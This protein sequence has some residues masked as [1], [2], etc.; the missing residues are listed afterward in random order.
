MKFLRDQFSIIIFLLLFAGYQTANHIGEN[1]GAYTQNDE[2]EP[3][4]EDYRLPK[5]II[6]THY[7]IMLS[8]KLEQSNFSGIVHIKAYVAKPTDRI[9]LHWGKI[10][11][12]KATVTSDAQQLIIKDYAYNN[13]TEKYAIILEKVLNV[14]TNVTISINYNGTL[15]DDMIGFYKSSYVD[16]NGKIR[17]LLSTQFQTT[18]AR[19]AFPCFDEPSFKASFIVRLFRSAEYAS[20]SNMP[21]NKTVKSNDMYWDEF[22]QS[23]PMS[24]YLVAFIISDFHSIKVENFRVWA[25]PNAIDQTRYALDIGTQGLKH[26]SKRFNQNYQIPKMDMVAVPDFSA[27]A[28]ENWGLI[29]YRESRLLYAEGL[30]S[31]V[32]KQSIASVIVHE[33]THMW[34]GNMITPE[35]WS[36]LWLSEAFARYFQYFGTA[37]IETTWNMEEQFVVEQHQTAYAADGVETSEPMTRDVSNASQ[38]SR[39]GDTITYNKG[40]SIVRMMNLIFGSEVFDAGLQNYLNNTVERVA[41]PENLWIELQSEINRNGQ[42][43]GASVKDI[44]T[45]WTEQAGFPVLSVSIKNNLA[46]LK[47][48]RFLLRNLKSTPTKLTWWIPLTWTTKA[49]PDFDRLNVQHWMSKELDTIDLGK[50]SGWVIFNIQ[51]SGFYRVNYDNASWYRIF[52]TLNSDNYKDVHVLNRAA[53]VDDLLNLARAGLLSYETTLDGLLY[54]MRE[55]NYLPFK[56]LFSGLTYLDQRLSGNDE[57]YKEF[58]KFVLILIDNI[59]QKIGYTDNSRDDRLTVLLRNELNKW[60]CN[61]GHDDCVKIFTNIFQQ[62]RQHNVTIAPNQHPVAYCMGVKHGTKEDWE[63]LW[64]EY[65]NSN[66]ATQQI[67]ILQALGCTEDAALLEKYLLYALKSFEVSRIRMQDNSAVFSA[68]SG[69]GITGAKFVLDFVANHLAEMV[70]FYNGTGS[71]SSILSS[72]SQRFSTQTLMDKFEKLIDKHKVEFASALVSLRNSLEIGKY[73]LNWSTKY[74]KQII[75]WIIKFNEKHGNNNSIKENDTSEYRLPE[76]ITPKSYSIR[77]ATNVSELDN[78]TFTGMVKINAVVATT[79]KSITLHSANLVNNN[80]S[81]L[82]GNTKIPISKIDI[83]ETYD[84]LIIELN[85]ELQPNQNLTI[86]I[87]FTGYLNEEMRGFYRSS[88]IDS[89]GQTRWLATTHMEPVGAR[90]MFPCFDEPAMKAKFTM[91]AVLP[92]NY[93]AISNMPI[94]TQEDDNER[95][96]IVFQETPTMS[97]YL[98]VLVVSDFIRVNEDTYSVW[99]RKNA[100]ND[101][102]YALSVMK[103]LVN[104]YEKTL[105]IPYQLP[106][107]DMV[108]LPDFVSGAM[109]NWGL[110]TYKERNVLYDSALSTTAS[111]QSIINV[112]SHEITHQWFGN[113]VSPRWWKYLWLN[114]GFARYFQYFGTDSIEQDW[115]L[116]AQFVVEQLHS[117]LE[118][119]SAASTH[120]MTHDVYSPTEIRGIFDSISYAKAASVIRMMKKVYGSDVFY[121]ALQNYLKKRQYD[122]A[123]PTDLFDAFKEQ[124]SNEQLRNS[125]HEIM[126][127]WTVQPGYPVVNVAIRGNSLELSQKRFL[128][129]SQDR[130]T[131]IWHI[132]ITWTNLNNPNFENIT[133]N[134]W[135]NK[136]RSTV[137]LPSDHLYLINLQQSGFYRVNY[138]TQ[139]W[140]RIIAFLKS[141]RYELIHEINRAALIDDLLNLG[142]AGQVDYS[143]VLSA[144]QYLKNETNYIPWRAFFNGLTYLQKQFEEREGYAAFV[145]YIKSLLTPLY[146]KLGFDENQNDDHVTKLFKSHIRKWA[147]KFDIADCRSNALSYFNSWNN[148]N[149]ALPPNIHSVSYCMAVEQ[150]S[151]GTWNDTVWRRLWDLYSQ[152]NFAAEKSII[153]QSLA[154]TTE[155][156]LLEELLDKAVS[157]DSGIRLEDSSSVFTY[158]TNSGPGGVQCVINFIR[159]NFDKMV[160]YYKQESNVHSI[161]SSVGKKIFTNE[162]YKQYFELLDFLDKKES[163]QQGT[164]KFKANNADQ[165]I[166]WANEHIPKIYE[167]LEKNYP[168]TDY[169]L[170]KTFR[171]SKYNVFLSP[172]FEEKGFKFD[173]SVQ[174]EMIRTANYVSCIVV[175]AYRLDINSLSVYQR[176]SNSSEKSELKVRSTLPNEETQMLSIFLDSFVQSDKVEL[177]INFTGTLNDDMEGF[178]RSYYTNSAGKISWLAATQFEPVYARQAF[179]CFDEPNLKATFVINI[180]RPKDYIAL[181]NMPR[182][183]INKSDTPGR[184]WDTFGET[185]E[186]STYLVAFVVSDFKNVSSDGSNINIW[187]RPDIVSRGD[188]AQTAATRLLDSLQSTTG[189]RYTLPKLDLIGIPDFSMGAMENWGLVTFREYG[190]FYE[191][192]ITSATQLDYIITT[193]A[194]ELSH[195]FF[196]NLVT[197][198]WWEYIWLNEG[199]AEYTQ[200]H[201]SDAFQPSFDYLSL[202]VVNELQ[203]AMLVDVSETTHPMT[204]PVAKP[205]V[206]GTVFDSITYA[207][208][209]SVIRMLHGSFKPEIYSKAIRKYLAD[210]SFKTA[211]PQNLWDAFD[212]AIKETKNSGKLNVSVATLMDGWVNKAGYPVVSVTLKGDYITLTQKSFRTYE[213]IDHFRIP[214]TLT[215]ASEMNFATTWTDTWLGGGPIKIKLKNPNEWFIVNVQQ[216]G[217][218]RVN[219]DR[220]SWSRLIKTLANNHTTIHSMNRAQII[221]DLFNLA[222]AGYVDYQLALDGTLFLKEEKEYVPWKAFVNAMNFILQRYQGQ[223]GYNLIREYILELSTEFYKELDITDT[224]NESHTR[225]LNRNLILTWLCQLDHEDC[226][227]RSVKIFRLWQTTSMNAI[228]PNVRQAIYCTAIRM[229]N[230]EHWDFLWQQYLKTNSPTEKKHMINAF[231]CSRNKTVLTTYIELAL[232]R[233]YT[234]AIR[235]QDVNAVLASVYNAGEFGVNAMLDFLINDYTKLHDYYGNWHDVK[236]LIHKLAARLSTRDQISK[237]NELNVKGDDQVNITMVIDEAVKSASKNIEWYEKY[238]DTINAW[239]SNLD[240]SEGVTLVVNRLLVIPMTVFSITVYMFSR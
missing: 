191:K 55:D 197:C 237:L 4:L 222:R 23:I 186:M 127:S 110:L 224:E 14:G 205:K 36:Y 166:K 215:T 25:R 196:G 174:I 179:P 70:E 39:V 230:S 75:S 236:D 71:I 85:Q 87:E 104:F 119:D 135:F 176:N 28:M 144:T 177:R 5:T 159:N 175:H 216:T 193:I 219:Y 164:Y 211:T 33:L 208:S 210:Q 155:K 228:S 68:V 99:A 76:D 178:Y 62:W 31:D 218:Y 165:E 123:E 187:G 90:K 92:L 131:C 213:D 61:Y 79:T 88:Y 229:G 225:Q 24:T 234:S 109:E 235:K 65:Y 42:K 9:T 64:N 26:L 190:L 227:L 139:T 146:S 57:Y 35:W 17:Q 86:T 120:A 115:S 82:V 72:A 194:H 30:T 201:L 150:Y 188:F 10:E 207:K 77:V 47:Q 83:N 96:T 84:F 125:V 74:A 157:K 128:L 169:R 239:I 124:I 185:V 21:L 195:M 100:I 121:K 221:D 32:A 20:L 168:V 145:R 133:V 209:A 141:D 43:L 203:P 59:Y 130:S 160:K 152:S 233:N 45:T 162:I 184:E 126:D 2:R 69:S 238:S 183:S 148:S 161:V 91:T 240:K 137:Q 98:V 151:G 231:G 170:P 22:H 156:H 116:E 7:E 67:V 153:L 232:D 27:G 206:I 18:H 172:H 48:E 117:A 113:L 202:F 134:Y 54:L 15:R 111:K 143:I 122:V 73:E 220:K 81:V 107:L 3:S 11:K 182:K 106:K 102:K 118:S 226:L 147:C 12:V 140:E 103:P 56:S 40:A 58:K 214:I 154:C 149:K 1:E 132:P 171:P 16:S 78:F 34:F 217:Y 189:H 44:M 93:S 13:K 204:N 101:G 108:A 199:F 142:K 192:N 8:P 19:H 105:N 167:W 41:R 38:V 223:K 136:S 80:I 49:N 200:Y 163:T 181:S 173:G 138:D 29:T 60:A 112:I 53:L 66:S 94:K 158:V 198:D 95:R 51:S 52:E 89:F 180:E 129:N 97:T 46:T 63:F 114:E 6:P 50:P 212:N 37:Q